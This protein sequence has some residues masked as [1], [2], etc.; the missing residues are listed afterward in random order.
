[1][2]TRCSICNKKIKYGEEYTSINKGIY[3]EEGGKDWIALI[4]HEECWH[5]LGMKA[6]KDII[7]LFEAE[8]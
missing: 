8:V 3:S 5:K 1:M 6:N 2:E 7:S 4:F